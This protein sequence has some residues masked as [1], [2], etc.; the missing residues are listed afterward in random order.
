MVRMWVDRTH[1]R[2]V[3]G[4]C[5][6]APAGRHRRAQPAVRPRVRVV[7][8]GQFDRRG[9]VL[10][11]A[12]SAASS[13]RPPGPTS[14]AASARLGVVGN[15]LTHRRVPRPRLRH[16]RH[17]RRHGGAP[18]DLRPGRPQRPLGQSAG[19]QGLPAPRLPGAL[20]V[21]G[22]PHPPARPAVG[23]PAI[24][25]S[26]LLP[27]QGDRLTMTAT[28]TDPRA[29]V[30]AAHDV[31]D[32]GP[33]GRRRPAHRMGRARDA[34]PP[35]HPRAVRARA[36]ARRPADRGLP[37]RHD[38]DRQPDAHA[39]GRR[40]RRSCSRASNPLSTKDDVAAALVAEYGIATYARRGEDRDTVLRAISTRS[41][42][43]TRRSR[44]TTAATSSRCSTAERP[45]QVTEVLA[46]TE[47][48]TT[49]RH[50][51]Q[52]DGRRRRAR[53]SRSWRSTRPRPSTSSTTA[54]APASRRSTASCG[55]PTSSSPD[56]TWSSPATAG[57]AAASRRG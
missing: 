7:A 38:R 2:P 25:A 50:P 55:R 45:D 18:A 33:G 37:P 23:R 28:S 29:G 4:R 31:T 21:R 43:R 36:A 16:G 20:P 40:R 10:R 27:P 12:A 53:A 22:A 54:T 30:T 8:A 6:Q 39:Q 17:G 47:E 52:G 48:T 19:A 5:P 57:S 34:G 35:A 15:V 9:R 14:S 44:W 46:G 49:G 26:P 32:L 41:P 11:D 56:A 24:G 3:P 51:A 1:F 42:T 13:W